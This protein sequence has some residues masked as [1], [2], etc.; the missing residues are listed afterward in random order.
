MPAGACGWRHVRVTLDVALSY[1]GMDPGL[2]PRSARRRDDNADLKIGHLTNKWAREIE[3]REPM[4]APD[5]PGEP[6]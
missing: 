3:S 6:Q 5:R 1:A 2:F 4:V